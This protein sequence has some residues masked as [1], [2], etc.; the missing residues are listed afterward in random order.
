MVVHQLTGLSENAAAAVDMSVISDHCEPRPT[1]LSIFRT[2]T[3]NNN[4]IIIGPAIILSFLRRNNI[5]N[6][7]V[8]N[9]II[10]TYICIQSKVTETSPTPTH[11]TRVCVCMILRGGCGG[12]CW[13][14]RGRPQQ[15][16]YGS[17]SS[18][19]QCSRVRISTGGIDK[20][21][22][23]HPAHYI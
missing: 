14:Y 17:S 7:N 6:E 18:S 23:S 22:G 21:V 15:S 1:Y 9:F 4:N 5:C 12:I 20:E 8:Q 16:T 3:N 13:Q 2:K 19:K 11:T 10:H